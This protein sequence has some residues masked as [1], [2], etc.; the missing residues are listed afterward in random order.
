MQKSSGKFKTWQATFQTVIAAAIVGQLAIACSNRD[1]KVTEHEGP[2]VGDEVI[3]APANESVKFDALKSVD[4]TAINTQ[5]SASRKKAVSPATTAERVE[6]LKVLEPF[7][8]NRAFLDEPKV[9]HT[10]PMRAALSAF[11]GTLVDLAD[12]EPALAAPWIEK[13]RVAIESGCDGVLHGCTN[14]AFFRG[15]GD[16]A[17]IMEL[18]ARSLN[19]AIDSA[20]GAERD[21]LIRLYYRRLGIAFDL[22]N[23]IADPQFEFMYLTRARDYTEAFGRAKENSRERDLL[24]RHSEVFEIIL[25]R[26]NPDLS[27]PAF[28]AQYEDFV[29]AFSPWNYS[30]RLENPFGQAATRMLSLAAKSF[31][32]NGKDGS[33]SESLVSSI[34]KSQ[35]IENPFPKCQEEKAAKAEKKKNDKSGDPLDSLDDSFASISNALKCEE[36]GLWKNLILKDSIPRDEYFFIVDRVYGDH[37]TPDDASEIW[38]G[39][40]RDAN[41]V[42]AAAEQYIKVQVA[43]QIVRTNRYM[44]TI[45][46][47]KEWSSA[48]LF[49]KAVEKSYPIST[50]WNQMLSRIDRIQLFLD[51][52]LKAPDEALNTKE[53]KHVSQ[54]LT[55]LR[56]NIKY[57]SVYPNMMLMA[58]YMAEVKFKIPVATFFGSYEIDAATIISWYFDGKLAPLFNFGNDGEGL[59][60]IETLYAFLFALKTETFKSFSVDVPRFFEVVIGK[61]LDADRIELEESLEGIRKNMRQSADMSKFLE[62]CRQDRELIAKGVKPGTQGNTLA[63]EFQNMTNGLYTGSNIGYGQ[64]A[65][66]FHGGTLIKNVSNVNE[67]LRKKL[68]FVSIMVGL[69]DKHLE[70]SGIDGNARAEL[71]AKVET[72]LAVIKRLQR[73]Y[74]TE[75]ISWNRQLSSCIDQSV[76]V[77]IDRQ[78]DAVEMEAA[79]LRQVWKFMKGLHGNENAHAVQAANDYLVSTLDLNGLS[80][81]AQYKPISQ[82]TA[83][84]YV[85]AELDVLLRL[86][87]NL[88]KIAPNVRI[89][90][91]ADL[92]DTGYWKA[93][94][95]VTLSYNPNENDFVREGLRNFNESGTAYVRWLSTVPDV[96]TF[97]NRLAL[98]VELYKL[99]NIEIYDTSAATCAGKMN[100]TECPIKTDFQVKASDIV[101]ETANVISLM[102]LTEPGGKPKRDTYYL[103]LLGATGRWTKGNLKKFT[104]DEN[105]DPTSLYESVY[106]SLSED[107]ATLNEV[108]EFNRT[109]KSVGNFLFAPEDAFN[110]ILSRGFGPLVNGHFA[111]VR[112]LEAAIKAREAADGKAGTVL[113]YG[114]EIREGT[115]LRTPIETTGGNPIYLARQK[116]DDFATRIMLFHR[117]T[118][119]S[120]NTDAK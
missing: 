61:Y 60:R 3:V 38:R 22:R 111:R 93:R 10:K 57:L 27:E 81:A 19:P 26:F 106:K 4:T 88:R 70:K 65:M 37:L 32:Y 31:L 116:M 92:T 82:I 108:R 55:S 42:L 84:E 101:N 64:D 1:V 59:K 97:S 102:S 75:I 16:S 91:P 20:T 49:Q 86:R 48:T 40:H 99:G 18:S 62:V 15:D 46:S 73:E 43:G 21:G 95:L 6:V 50:Q 78:N 119:N 67:S 113:D 13:T 11:I 52:N 8:L 96:G 90:M 12:I 51:R 36:M 14:I 76:K 41:A 109:T 103:G 29:N 30:R 117:E 63:I 54:M 85:Y 35:E 107:E 34:K 66:N 105:G 45:Y 80:S 87:L 9:I 58:Y 104:L 24:A 2:V 17:K 69:Y 23:Q 33:L 68:D 100:I 115:V 79:H 28:R 89:L 94:K 39:S 114:Y 110:E 5:I 25:N 77:E 98:L 71:K 7:V 120:F 74:L 44:N 118:A 112:A 83:D 72:N 56:R 47:N 53:Y